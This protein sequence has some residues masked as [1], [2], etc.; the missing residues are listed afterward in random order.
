[1]GANDDVEWQCRKA[2]AGDRAP[3]RRRGLLWILL[4]PLSGGA[5]APRV[6]RWNRTTSHGSSSTAL[7]WTAR[8]VGASPSPSSSFL[9]PTQASQPASPASLADGRMPGGYH[10]GPNLAGLWTSPERHDRPDAPRC[11]VSWGASARHPG[12]FFGR[13]SAIGQSPEADPSDPFSDR[14]PPDR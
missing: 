12:P 2:R 9:S 8:C 13:S 4:W 5:R 6:G 11:C 14:H 10:G 3:I 1:M 7:T